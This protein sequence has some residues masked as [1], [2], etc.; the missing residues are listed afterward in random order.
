MPI[1][2]YFD[3]EAEECHAVEYCKEHKWAEK[4][5]DLNYRYEH[6][7]IIMKKIRLYPLFKAFIYILKSN[8]T[9]KYFI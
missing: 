8:A 7:I 2:L 9:L 3:R 1:C 4:G 5:M 6:L